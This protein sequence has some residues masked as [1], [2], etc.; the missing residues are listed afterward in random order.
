[1]DKGSGEGIYANGGAD[2]G[3]GAAVGV[4]AVGI[5]HVAGDG[6]AGDAEGREGTEIRAELIG[7]WGLLTAD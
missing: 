2:D 6:G 1:M 5:V 7:H 4:G 3:D